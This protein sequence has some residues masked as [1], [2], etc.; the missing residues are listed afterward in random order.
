MGTILNII[1]PGRNAVFAALLL[2]LGFVPASLLAQLQV[3]VAGTDASC[4]ELNNGLA[5]VSVS[6]GTAPYTYHWN[7]GSS[8]LEAT[9][10]VPGHYIVT[11]FDAQGV[12]ATASTTIELSGVESLLVIQN[13]PYNLEQTATFTAEAGYANYQWTL[14]NPADQIID[15]QGTYA[16]T[17][18]WHA[19]GPK[20]IQVQFSNGPTQCA[21]TLNYNVQVAT[22]AATDSPDQPDLKITPNPFDRRIEINFPDNKSAEHNLRLTDLYGRTLA[23]QTS[24]GAETT[25]DTPDLP[26]GQYLLWCQNQDQFLVKKL[27]KN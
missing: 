3:T 5:K 7:N 23:R 17:V 19:A 11:V 1:R 2:L 13:E 22:A 9:G 24:F 16:I 4:P 21:G 27:I 20:N 26:H 8:A 10:L 15:G 14:S 18:R 12:T 6:N 25:L